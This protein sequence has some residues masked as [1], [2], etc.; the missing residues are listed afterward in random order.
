M[1]AQVYTSRF[2]FAVGQTAGK[3]VTVAIVLTL[4]AVAGFG[5]AYWHF[6]LD[7][8]KKKPAA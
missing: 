8:N 3:D 6:F 1:T 5:P 4:V 2:P 7:K